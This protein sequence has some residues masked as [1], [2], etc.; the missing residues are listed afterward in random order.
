MIK[1]PQD[2]K[3]GGK[4]NSFLLRREFT[5]KAKPSTAW[6]QYT[7]DDSATVYVNGIAISTANDWHYPRQ[8]EVSP[9]LKAG[10][11]VLAF[12]YQNSRSAGGVLAELY[13]AYPD[14]SSEKINTDGKF[15]AGLREEPGWNKPGFSAKGWEKVI[16]QFGPPTPPW[17]YK[18]AYSDFSR[19]QTFISG[20][21]NPATADAGKKVNARFEFSG[22]IPESPA[23]FKLTLLK[24]NQD[25]WNE[26]IVLQK[27]NLKTL[28][29]GRWAVDFDYELPHYLRSADLTM[30]LSSGSIFCKSGGLP[31][32]K[33]TYRELKTAPGF[34]NKITS[35]INA[36]KNGPIMMLNEKPFFPVWGSVNYKQRPDKTYRFGDAPLNV[37]TVGCNYDQNFYPSCGKFVSEALDRSAE[38]HRRDYG[39]DVLFMWDI[40]LYP[41]LDWG[42]KNK[43]EMALDDHGEINKDGRTNHSFASQRALRDMKEILIKAIDYLEKSPYANRIV[44]YRVNGGHTI[45]W[46]GWDPKPGRILDFSPVTKKAFAEFAEKHYPELKDFTVPSLAER[47]QLDNGELLW[48]PKK[49][50]RVIAYHDFY[51]NAVADMLIDLCKAAKEKLNHRKVVGTYYGYTS[52]LH[53]SGNSQMRAHYA[54]KKVLDSKAVDFLMSPQAY[55]IRNIGDTCGDMK[56]FQSMR[57]NNIIP[58][59]EDDTRTH[60]GPY[61]TFSNNFQ[62]LTKD[63]TIAVM[64]RNMGI[65]IA[66]NLPIYYY[67]LCAGTEYDFPEMT[68][69]IATLRKLG[70]HCVKKDIPRAADIALVFSEETIKSMPMYHRNAATNG[71]FMQRYRKDGSV[72]KERVGSTVLTGESFSN[73][74]TRYARSG[75]AT[76]YLLAEDLADHP[77]NY[78]LYVF[79]NSFKYDAKF[80]AAVNELKKRDCTLFWVYAPG[81]TCENK[82][83][84]ENMKILTGFDFVK[85]SEPLMP[86]VKLADGRWMGTPTTR[87][88]PMFSVKKNTS[89]KVLGVYED[90]T[91][92]YAEIRTGKARSIFCGAYQFDV[93]FL[94]ELVRKSGAHIYSETSDPMEANSA[95]FTLHARFP[96]RKTVRLPKKTDVLDVMNR[97]LIAK[98]VNTFTFEAPLHSSWIFYY[99]N[100]AEDLLKKLNK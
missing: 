5:L 84:V 43:E 62:T 24:N 94:M 76:D 77:G 55:G 42:E 25:I 22:K 87:I 70:E 27:S 50:E 66:R 64:R 93:P 69:D 2:L 32:A 28:P 53:A 21:I 58:V 47:R 38:Q 81:Y 15:L 98:N 72:S 16:E 97:K 83:S 44:G 73:N 18:M 7:A 95:L 4:Y 11:N 57:M 61:L 91:A 31:D 35:R 78:K 60:N 86:A 37:V 20:K 68:S 90:G 36:G 13:I 6:L 39:P 30:R 33:F 59:I 29:D 85:A 9:E 1:S 96:G 65:A 63:A 99:G 79:V 34:E 14:G 89:I 92:G 41:P 80:L 82:N 8:D 71:Y 74:L 19:P 51:S 67:A 88:K 100:D 40:S 10:K 75:A 46:L 23:K 26:E 45:E 3:S 48:D 49:H 12:R 52:T 17:V 56:P 54:L